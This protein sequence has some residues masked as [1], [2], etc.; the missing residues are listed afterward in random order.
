MIIQVCAHTQRSSGH[1]Q[2][3]SFAN[4]QINSWCRPQSVGRTAR[5]QC[6]WGPAVLLA[7]LGDTALQLA[8]PWGALSSMPCLPEKA[9]VRQPLF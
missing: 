6:D 9:A 5:S 3:H 7:T 1:A 2:C 4:E 8:K